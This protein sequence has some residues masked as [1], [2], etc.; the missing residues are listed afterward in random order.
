MTAH[1]GHQSREVVRTAEQVPARPETLTTFGI[2]GNPKQKKIFGLFLAHNG[3]EELRDRL[4]G[5]KLQEGDLQQLDGYRDRFQGI[6]REVQEAD[7]LHST[8]NCN[9][10]SFCKDLVRSQ[11]AKSFSGSVIDKHNRVIH[12]LLC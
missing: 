10:F 8:L 7:G 3:R 2:L 11:I 4:F 5:G 9:Q 1:H 6:Y 12:H